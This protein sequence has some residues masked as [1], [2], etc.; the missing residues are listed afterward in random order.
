MTSLMPSITITPCSLNCRD[1]D[2]IA[3]NVQPCFCMIFFT[4]V[5]LLFV[6]DVSDLI[7][8][9]TPSGPYPS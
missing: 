3:P 4:L 9:A 1:T 5:A 6:L 2:P 7:S 8:N